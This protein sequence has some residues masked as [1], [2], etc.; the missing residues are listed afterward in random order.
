MK[1]GKP[2]PPPTKGGVASVLFCLKFYYTPWTIIDITL[3]SFLFQWSLQWIM[4]IEQTPLFIERSILF[5]YVFHWCEINLSFCFIGSYVGNNIFSEGS[6][7]M[8]EKR[9]RSALQM[10]EMLFPCFWCGLFGRSIIL[11]CLKHLTPYWSI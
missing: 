11:V 9:H 1:E 4:G 10:F 7:S 5:M 8:L 2:P 6:F 3:N